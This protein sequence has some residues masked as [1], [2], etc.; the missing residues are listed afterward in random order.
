MGFYFSSLL[1][2]L[3]VT[4]LVFQLVDLIRKKKK[5]NVNREIEIKGK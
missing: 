5:A 4:S 1:I 3:V 2:G